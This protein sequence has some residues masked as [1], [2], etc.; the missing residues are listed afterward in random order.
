MAVILR[1]DRARSRIAALFLGS[2]VSGGFAVVHL[3]P[4][5]ST[6]FWELQPSV[7]SWLLA[8][9]PA[10]VGVVLTALA[11]SQPCP[12]PARPLG[13]V[14]AGTVGHTAGQRDAA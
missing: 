13:D 11:W 3:L 9:M 6:S 8:W 5:L 2:S 14:N 4:L 7:V 10:A 1:G 12:A